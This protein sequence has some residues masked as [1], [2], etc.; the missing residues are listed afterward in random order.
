[1]K[2]AQKYAAPFLVT[3]PAD[4]FY[5]TGLNLEG[6]WLMIAGTTRTV[7]AP[8]LLAG[9]VRERLPYATIIAGNSMV[10]SLVKYCRE[11]RIKKVGIDF[12]KISY[13]S[14]RLIE[15]N[16]VIENS[17]HCIADQRIIKSSAEREHISRAC[18]IAIRTFETVRRSIKPGMT[19]NHIAFKIEEIFSKKNVRSSFTPIVAFGPNTANPHHVSSSRKLRKNDIVLIDM[20][21]LFNGYASDLTRTF[22]IGKIDYLYRTVY[23]VVSQAHTTAIQGV[24]PGI[25]ANQVD[26]IARCIIAEA[27][28]GKEF[29]HSTG[30]GVGI[31]VH[32][33]P[34][35][36]ISDTTILR[37]GMVVTVEP[38]IYLPGQFGVRIED[39]VEVTAKGRK[40]LTQ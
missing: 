3:H 16:V 39:T 7:F 8:E 36:S 1:M 26:G 32:E 11:N 9:Q 22:A 2:P 12:S 30:H 6:F 19:E 31:E 38:G 17:A 33:P 35:L 4:I 18:T 5:L 25:K 21:C 15:K 24:L 23:S 40:V 28:Y 10:E 20:G 34:R 27:G 13:S 29:I 14:A 37:T